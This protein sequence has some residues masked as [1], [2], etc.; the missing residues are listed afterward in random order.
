MRTRLVG[1]VVFFMRPR[2]PE[3]D[4]Q[5]ALTDVSDGLLRGLDRTPGVGLTNEAAL[6]EYTMSV[7]VRN[8]D[9]DAGKLSARLVLFDV[10][11][12]VRKEFGLVIDDVRDAAAVQ[13]SVAEV[14][15]EARDWILDRHG[16]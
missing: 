7:W 1:P 15:A 2:V 11:D 14:L 3:L 8:Y 9:E 10:A 13:A 16:D 4:A 6:A 5:L 12:R